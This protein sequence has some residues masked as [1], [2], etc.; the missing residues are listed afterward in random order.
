[1][2]CLCLN[3]SNFARLPVKASNKGTLLFEG[4]H[5][6]VSFAFHQC[7]RCKYCFVAQLETKT[8][9]I[10]MNNPT[11]DSER[12][13][14]H[15]SALHIA[16]ASFYPKFE[17][18]TP[19]IDTIELNANKR[20]SPSLKK[21]FAM[22]LLPTFERMYNLK[23]CGTGVTGG[24]NIA[25]GQDGNYKVATVCKQIPYTSRISMKTFYKEVYS[26]WLKRGCA[27]AVVDSTTAAVTC[28]NILLH[29]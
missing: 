15:A 27:L 8:G 26:Y 14:I 19:A 23:V 17:G 29:L 6:K 5:I 2:N 18:A 10:N 13:F 1:M 7:H 25:E 16:V 4:G 9:I 3:V 21:A 24:T 22:R 11:R 28:A 12:Y 20:L